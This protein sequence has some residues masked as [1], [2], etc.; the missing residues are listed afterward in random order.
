LA[1]SFSFYLQIPGSQ[2]KPEIWASS[3]QVPASNV[4]YFFTQES[5]GFIEGSAMILKEREEGL[6]LQVRKLGFKQENN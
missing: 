2:T 3:L 1:K 5:A 4:T 6:L